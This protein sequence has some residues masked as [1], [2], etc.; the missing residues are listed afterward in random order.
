M[1]RRSPEPQIRRS[2][3]SFASVTGRS[4]TE[5]EPLPIAASV[6]ETFFQRRRVYEAVWLSIGDGLTGGDVTPTAATGRL[7]CA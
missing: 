2:S 5:D 4:R 1:K 6:L 7:A 3:H